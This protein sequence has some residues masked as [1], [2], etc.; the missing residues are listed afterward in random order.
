MFAAMSRLGGHKIG[1][2]E[3]VLSTNED[4]RRLSLMIGLQQITTRP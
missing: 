3:T 4:A 2:E 1:P